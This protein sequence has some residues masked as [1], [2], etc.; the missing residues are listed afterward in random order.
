[1]LVV[2]FQIKTLSHILHKCC[3]HSKTK[4]G[5]CTTCRF[6]FPRPEHD[7]FGICSIAESVAGRKGIKS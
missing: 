4:A 3:M 2:K 1:M 6:D 5:I 7:S